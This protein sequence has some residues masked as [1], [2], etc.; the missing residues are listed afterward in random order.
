MLTARLKNL[1]YLDDRP[2]FPEDRRFSEAF[3]TGGLEAERLERQKFK[4]EENERRE[5]NRRNFQEF[6]DQAKREREEK[7][8]A[9]QVR[10]ISLAESEEKNLE[11][12]Y[13]DSK[14]GDSSKAEDKS[15]L[16]KSESKSI[17]HSDSEEKN[18]SSQE[19]ISERKIES[20]VIIEFT[21]EITEL[22]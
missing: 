11:T 6:I 9:A 8:S 4:E 16:N 2:V 5:E 10:E 14:E 17:D 15:S 7:E 12:Y 18:T 20:K 13:S 22:D 3:Y 21:K 19:E 1:K